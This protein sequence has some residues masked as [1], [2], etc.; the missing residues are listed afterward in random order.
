VSARTGSVSTVLRLAIVR[1]L[2]VAE[3]TRDLPPISNIRHVTLLQG[4]PGVP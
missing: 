1:A 3:P 2:G 4:G